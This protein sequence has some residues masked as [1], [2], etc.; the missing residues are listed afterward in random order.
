MSNAIYPL[1]K[2]AFLSGTINMASGTIQVALVANAYT[3]SST[4]QFWSNVSSSVV[5][6]PVTLTSVSVTN[7]VFN[8][9]NATF[10]AVTGNQV[11]SAVI[12]NNTGTPSTS[13]LIAY[14]DSGTG[15]PVL[16]NGGDITLAWDAGTN[17]IFS[18]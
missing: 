11:K 8:A 9:A 16:P 3:Y 2:Q 15:L 12:F 18:L 17:H 10:S 4:D 14:I 1:A 6:S 7:G 13:Q 5:G